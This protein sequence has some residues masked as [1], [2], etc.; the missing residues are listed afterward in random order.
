M[1]QSGEE[2]NYNITD[3]RIRMAVTPTGTIDYWNKKF[4]ELFVGMMMQENTW[5]KDP[6]KISH[7]WGNR[8][9]LGQR[10]ILRNY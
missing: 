6:V 4:V 1:C 2:L 3:P 10:Q 5:P 8:K 7:A 9:K